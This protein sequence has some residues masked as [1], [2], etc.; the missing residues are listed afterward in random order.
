MIKKL[1]A[2]FALCAIPSFAQAEV[3]EVK[4]G[5][6]AHNTKLLNQKNGGKEKGPDIEGQVIFSPIE[7][8]EFMGSP[9]PLVVA[10]LNTQGE[11][12]FGGVGLTWEFKPTQKV[13]FEPFLGLVYHN[14]KH[15]DNPYAPS[16]SVNR[17]YANAH[18]L[19]LG[20]RELFWLGVSAGYEIKPDLKIYG[21]YEHLSHGQIL[22]SGV[23]EG[24]DNIGILIGKKF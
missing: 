20:S 21:I 1:I 8:L 17:A 2:M 15:L 19:M 22:H 13:T 12:S 6:F 4:L 24:V 23:N 14:G 9:R 7:S 11:T 5:V 10:S 16:D 18:Y 3:T